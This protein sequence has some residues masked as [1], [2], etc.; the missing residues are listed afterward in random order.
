MGTRLNISIEIARSLSRVG[1]FAG[2]YFIPGVTVL[3]IYVRGYHHHHNY[4]C[5]VALNQNDTWYVSIF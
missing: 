1:Y 3:K 4:Y 2:V 5:R